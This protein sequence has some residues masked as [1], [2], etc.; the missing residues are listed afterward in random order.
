MIDETNFDSALDDAL[1]QEKPFV[2]P[3]PQSASTEPV[4]DDYEPLVINNVK[5]PRGAAARIRAMEPDEFKTWVADR[6]K[7]YIDPIYLSG[8]LGMDLQEDPQRALFANLITL[9]GP[10]VP[11]SELDT[12]HRKMLLW[13]RGTCKTTSVRCLEVE[14][15]LNYP[16][17][18]L[19]FLT[20]SDEL[21]KAQLRA[22]K[23]LFEEPTER[24]EYLFPEFT[25]KSVWNK[26]TSQWEDKRVEMG[27]SQRFS[28]PARSNTVLAESTFQISTA[29]KVK[30]GSHF[31]F[32]F[33]DDLVNETNY[34]NA[35]VLERCYQNYID[36]VPE[37]DPSGYIVMTGTRYSHDD[38]YGRILEKAT[39]GEVNLWSFSI[40]D[41]YSRGKCINC[42]HS[43]VFHDASVN[44]LQPP[45]M[46][47]C[48]GFRSDGIPGVIF[49]QVRLKDGRLLGFTLEWLAQ[50]RAEMGDAKF[51]NQY[52]NQAVAA[53]QQQFTEQMI[54]TQTIF[55]AKQLPPW[56]TETFIVGDLAYTPEE[57]TDSKKRD[58]TVFWVFKRYH[59]ALWVY[60]GDSGRWGANDLVTHILTAIK[61]HRPTA[62]FL[63]KNAAADAL[64]NQIIARAPE[65]M[66]SKIPIQWIPQGNVKDQKFVRI[67]GIAPVL[68][69]K[70]LW[71]SASMPGYEKLKQQLL[72][73][74]RARHDDYADTLGLCVECPTGWASEAVPLAAVETSL[75]WLRRLNPAA[76]VAP[77][78]EDSGAGSGLC[79]GPAGSETAGWK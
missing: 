66:I 48:P 1:A 71:L 57:T 10:Q 65:F 52:L 49:P 77:N 2:P 73:F 60:D 55:D 3:T 53:S 45:C 42:H 40:R 12:I 68:V 50:Q 17:A 14:I 41:C 72:Q 47:G 36:L 32:I 38:A 75:D 22:L 76:P 29:K 54:H 70:R 61:K 5:F 78:Y 20:G 79:A 56:Q 13:S 59:G 44:V 51:S 25:L 58:E 69:G 30:A 31:D 11:W 64:M 74:P 24:F 62:F 46:C 27:N 63:E 37:L 43:D 39:T 23:L 8:I 67:A 6:Q 21:G 4:E 28:V 34:Q 26:K 9:R 16:N 18:R 15:I 33:I 35:A 7:A 19:C